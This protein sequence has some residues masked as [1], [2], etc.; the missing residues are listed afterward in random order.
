M[1]IKKVDMAE[2]QNIPDAEKKQG[3]AMTLHDLF[4]D[5]GELWRKWQQS[6]AIANWT[7]RKDY[8]NSLPKLKNVA[9]RRR[10]QELRGI[11]FN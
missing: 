11:W 7:H 10:D 4:L 5:K 3:I 2:Y 9:T 8:H 6:Y 1:G